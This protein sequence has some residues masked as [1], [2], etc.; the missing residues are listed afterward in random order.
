MITPRDPRPQFGVPVD[1]E[2][3]QA[4][5]GPQFQRLVALKD[6]ADLL[7]AAMHAA[8]GSAPP[9]QHQEH[10]WTSRRMG[11][12]ATHVETAIM[13]AGRAALESP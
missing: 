10:T 4:L 1:S 12:A 2:T 8:D 6:A 9:G 7:Y 5:T 3:G 11:I 13:Y